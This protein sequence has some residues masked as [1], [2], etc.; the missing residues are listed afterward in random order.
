MY[1]APHFL[2]LRQEKQRCQ[3]HLRLHRVS[4]GDGIKLSHS[5]SAW[6][7]TMHCCIGGIPHKKI[8]L[9]T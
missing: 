4:H 2:D 6:K 7:V 3:C 8:W 5:L 1:P 9:D